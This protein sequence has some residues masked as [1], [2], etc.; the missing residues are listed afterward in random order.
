[1]Q[2]NSIYIIDIDFRLFLFFV[3][4]TACAQLQQGLWSAF[5]VINRGIFVSQPNGGRTR[6]TRKRKIGFFFY[7]KKP[8]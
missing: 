3:E 4:I 8:W 6:I 2:K 1:M 5:F 7:A